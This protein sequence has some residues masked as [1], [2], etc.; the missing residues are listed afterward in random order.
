MIGTK[1][2]SSG[3]KSL[4]PEPKKDLEGDGREPAWKNKVASLAKPYLVF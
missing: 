1:Y 4:I 2:H 3:V